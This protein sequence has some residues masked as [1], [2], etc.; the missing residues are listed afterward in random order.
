VPLPGTDGSQI[1]FD[2]I[3]LA[4]Q[5]IARTAIV[6][7]QDV[8]DLGSEARVNTPGAPEGNWAWRVRADQLDSAHAEHL[9][10]LTVLYGRA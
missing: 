10:E 7:L 8:L 4:L 1:A 2:L 6:P 5:S 3:R 9:A